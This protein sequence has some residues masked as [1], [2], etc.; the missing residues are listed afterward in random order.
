MTTIQPKYMMPRIL[1]LTPT[2]P[3]GK[4]SKTYGRPSAELLRI[5]AAGCNGVCRFAPSKNAVPTAVTN[6]GFVVVPK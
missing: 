3:L 5:R 6:D 4:V 2:V 1:P